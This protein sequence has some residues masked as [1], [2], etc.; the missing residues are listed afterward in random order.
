MLSKETTSHL[1]LFPNI[2]FISSRAAGQNLAEN[3]KNC[4][5]L[6]V[7]DTSWQLLQNQGLL[8]CC[9]LNTAMSVSNN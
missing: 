1:I 4:I 9:Q 5:D 2:F 7:T 6:G 8:I 3:S